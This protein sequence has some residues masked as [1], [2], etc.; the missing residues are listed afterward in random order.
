MD[1]VQ[2]NHELTKFYMET[3]EYEMLT[4][5]QYGGLLFLEIK[6]NDFWQMEKRKQDGKKEN[7]KKKDNFQFEKKE[8]KK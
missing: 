2:S 7:K 6:W 8:K 4:V 3:H 1:K 5:M